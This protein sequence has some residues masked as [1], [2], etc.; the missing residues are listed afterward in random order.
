MSSSII[1]RQ[2]DTGDVVKSPCRRRRSHGSK[3]S[4]KAAEAARVEAGPP[5]DRLAR[6]TFSWMKPV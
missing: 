6:K 3:G 2:L 1:F 5:E 4:A